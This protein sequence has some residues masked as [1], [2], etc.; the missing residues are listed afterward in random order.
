MRIM[1]SARAKA[2]AVIGA[3]AAMASIAMAAPGPALAVE[4]ACHNP[5]NGT[6]SSL[7]K[8]QQETWT[9]EATALTKLHAEC[10]GK[11]TVKYFPE[12]SGAGL[13][14]FGME[15]GFKLTPTLGG[16]K[17]LD[18]FIGTDDPPTKAQL[19]EVTLSIAGHAET[20]A[21]VIAPL[22]A[23]IAM[24]MHLPS[25]CSL[26]TGAE[27]AV[28]RK[29][30]EE[31]WRHKGGS[32]QTMLASG[33]A[34]IKLSGASCTE[35]ALAEKNIDEVRSDGSGTSY[36]FKQWMCQIAGEGNHE[37]DK[38]GEKCEEDKGGV[39]EY[40]NDS[41]EWPLQEIESLATGGCA[42]TLNPCSEEH[43][44]GTLGKVLNEK[45]PGEAN[46]VKETE[47]SIGYAN[48]AD[49]EKE[50]F[51]AGGKST[52]SSFW[53][54]VENGT[55]TPEPF[56]DPLS[57]T[58]GNCTSNFSLTAK[59]ETEAAKNEW[60][61]V[62][63]AKGKGEIEH[64]PVCTLTY[65]VGW[66]SYTTKTLVESPYY[67]SEALAEEIRH[68]TKAYFLWML[69]ATEGQKSIDN[70]YSEAPATVLTISRTNAEGI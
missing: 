6:G 43:I 68:A 15:A 39:D 59:Q 8:V 14:E 50:G 9:A 69:G 11:I 10:T 54:M 61:T 30:L 33:G 70:D 46:A 13:T 3:S 67:E 4:S 22:A 52:L 35:T 5:L 42:S 26:Q 55:V 44:E 66:K 45:G 19:T 53:V 1:D 28:T 41:K 63:F 23:P 56:A 40:I 7:Q 65:D 27:P 20:E 38:A 37:W 51:E 21:V 18:G 47:N 31:F 32:W 58:K 2:L 62:H 24:I 64:Y 17:K 34:A 29:A 36:A 25:G 60:G 16:E 12:G 49:A 57:G 48:T